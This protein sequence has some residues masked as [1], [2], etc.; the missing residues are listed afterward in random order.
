[1][2]QASQSLPP[3][4]KISALFDQSLFVRASIYGVLREGLIAAALDGLHDPVFLGDW[5]PTIVISISIPLSIFV[6]IILLG[7][8]GRDHQHHDA[9]RSGARRRHPGGR[10]HSGDRKH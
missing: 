7:A 8:L 4:L 2:Q 5:R 6:S 10:R 9:W 3:E 1:M